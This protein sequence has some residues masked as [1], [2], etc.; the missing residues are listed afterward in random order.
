ML[1]V[2]VSFDYELFMGQNYVSEEEVLLQPT[3]KISKMLN[4][5]GISA[6]FFAD[7]CCPEAYRH[8]GK[9][10]FADAFDHQLQYLTEQNHDV[11]LH[12]HPHWLKATKVGKTVE[13]PREFFRIHK[14][15]D[16][17]GNYDQVQRIIH[18][19]ID[20]LNRVIKPV[21]TDYRCLAFRAGGYCLQPEKELAACLYEEGIRIDSS[22]C[23]GLSYQGDGM[24]YDYRTEPKFTNVRINREYGF[25]DNMEKQM[26]NSIL[27][28]PVAGYST[29]PYKLLARRKNCSMGNA[30]AK[31]YGMKLS[32]NGHEKKRNLMQRI[33]R[34]LGTSNM[35]TFD[36]YS[37]DAM[38]YM[39]KRIEKENEGKDVFIS[40]IAHPKAQTDVHIENMKIAIQT[41][42]LF[43]VFHS[44][45][46]RNT[47]NN[48]SF[49]QS[50]PPPFF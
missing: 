32:A 19:G 15:V 42:P 27:E 46:F 29:F 11:Q 38:I 30:D 50:L 21:Y 45:T 4:E 40:A 2:C 39:L 26:P 34:I 5:L 14:W 36:F 13:F 44:P 49:Y 7:I 17:D 35:V 16:E 10:A 28:V 12:I 18:D 8:L 43:F 41:P 33:K 31:G 20:Y 48:V 9:P 1:Y 3:E 37:A 47:T 24:L 22:V 25:S 23:Q 6:T